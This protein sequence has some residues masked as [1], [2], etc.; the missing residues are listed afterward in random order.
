MKPIL[1]TIASWICLGSAAVI[2]FLAFFGIISEEAWLGL[3]P[4]FLILVV[5]GATLLHSRQEKTP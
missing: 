5:V 3:M 1:A 4:V 2:I